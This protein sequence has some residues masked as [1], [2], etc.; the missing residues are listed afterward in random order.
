MLIKLAF[1]L[2]FGKLALPCEVSY[3]QQNHRTWNHVAALTFVLAL[4]SPISCLAWFPKKSPNMSYF[5]KSFVNP[6]DVYST[7]CS[8]TARVVGKK[9]SDKSKKLCLC[10]FFPFILKNPPQC[11][12]TGSKKWELAKRR[13]TEGLRRS[14]CVQT[15]QRWACRCYELCN[16]AN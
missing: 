7:M 9:S 15:W 3:S 11:L 13:S 5:M 1:P 6:P 14:H 4:S 12:R 16:L 8:K 2:F 10:C